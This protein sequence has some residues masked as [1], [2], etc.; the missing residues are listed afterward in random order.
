MDN[1]ILEKL[2]GGAKCT[3]VNEKSLRS[4]RP[5]SFTAQISGVDGVFTLYPGTV[6]FVGTFEG[7]NSVCVLMNDHEMFRF[8]GLA[9][10]SEYV[11]KGRELSEF[12]KLGETARNKKC[13]FEYWTQ[14]QGESKYPARVCG[15][16]Y[17]KQNP[18]DILDGIYVPPAPV[19]VVQ[20][21]TPI[22][23]EAEFT[24]EED[25]EWDTL[26][27]DEETVIREAEAEEAARAEAELMYPNTG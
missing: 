8:G 21:S 5:A 12:F 25:E 14:W 22:N 24:P 11:Q 17:Y 9:E 19:V 10:V 16:V 4:K 7:A 18:I 13:T 6:E 23:A 26:D 15:R 2:S 27:W 1:Q 3:L 20:D